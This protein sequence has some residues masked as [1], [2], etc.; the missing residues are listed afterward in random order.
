[1]ESNEKATEQENPDQTSAPMYK[2]E[3]YWLHAVLF[4]LTLLT[5]TLSGTE[6]TLGRAF[7]Y[8]PNPLLLSDLVVGLQFSIPFL[9]ILT[10]HEMG[11][12]LVARYYKVK[13]T[14]P[15]YIPAWFGFLPPDIAFPSI[16]TFGAYI[17]IKAIPRTTQQFFDIGIAGPLVGFVVATIFLIIGYLTLPT[18]DYVFGIHPEFAKWGNEY[19]KYAYSEPNL[20]LGTNL[21]MQWLGSVFADP[22]RLPNQYE[23]IHYPYLFAGYLSLLFTSLNLLPIG[24]LDGGHILYGLLGY[25]KAKKIMP[26]IFIGLVFA[27]GISLVTPMDFFSIDLVQESLIPNLML[28]VAYYIALSKTFPVLRQNIAISLGIFAIQYVIKSV[29]P[30]VTGADGYFMFALL[31]GRFLGTTHPPALIEH[32]LSNGRKILGVIAFIV[33]LICFIPAPFQISAN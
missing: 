7:F 11:H 14:L 3:K 21:F 27:V 5:T 13:A 6:W 23:L 26:Y 24:Q 33:F 25:E 2:P 17:K 22:E 18:Q 4:L 29:F 9:L 10:S 1:L 8:G 12:Y 19:S 32:P 28:L 20:K 16:G 30:F 31:L 15:F